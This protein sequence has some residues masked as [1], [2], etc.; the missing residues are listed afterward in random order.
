MISFEGLSMMLLNFLRIPP[1]TSVRKN[2]GGQNSSTCDSVDE[3]V[4][5]DDT[6]NSMV[7]I[8]VDDV[9]IGNSP[10]YLKFDDE[11]PEEL[12]D[13]VRL[14]Q[15][16]F[17]KIAKWI[18]KDLLKRGFSVYDVKQVQGKFV[19]LPH[20]APVSFYL[21]AF[22]DIVALGED[23][24][25]LPAKETL[26]FINY[27]REGLSKVGDQFSTEDSVYQISVSPVPIQL[28]NV[29]S[30][31]KD[32]LITKRSILRYRA[33]LSRIVRFASVDIGVSQGQKQQDV[34]DGISEAINANSMSLMATSDETANYD[35]NIP[36]IPN[37]KGVGKPELTTDVPDSK[38]GDLADLDSLKSE[39]AL[40]MRFPKTYSDFSQ[41]LG[42]TAASTLRGDVRY[43]RMVDT[44]RSLIE[45]TVNEFIKFCVPDLCDK[46]HIE[47]NLTQYP[48]PEDE[49]VISTISSFK[50]FLE[51]T[52]Q[53]VIKD[54]ESQVEAQHK[55][56]LLQ[57]L[58]G[59]AANIPSI[60]KFM[61]HLNE[62]IEDVIP[63]DKSE[64]DSS[65]LDLDSEG[66]DLGS[67]SGESSLVQPE[68]SAREFNLSEEPS[69]S[70][71]NI[72]SSLEESSEPIES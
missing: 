42:E 66:S 49:D 28:K 44:A 48:Q 69:A 51:E 7:E 68:A 65:D 4:S 72:Q 38:I 50:D 19:V 60:Q 45:D 10:F 11:I 2:Y 71:V 8:T 36:V 31:A 64:E 24:E 13:R 14:I 56:D 61:E 70:D 63:G 29:S 55:A 46:F 41:A 1:G 9:C 62:A 53:L 47:F 33:Q 35:D 32:L 57:D 30:V 25:T 15:K 3:V 67:V 40:A 37:R 20:L 6:I 54:S 39:L 27:E 43:S 58:L 21:N 22:G 52:Y 16:Q 17:N 34:I 5:N 23:G 18:A 59:N 26:I 12:L